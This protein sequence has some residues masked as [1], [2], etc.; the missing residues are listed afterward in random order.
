MDDTVASTFGL[1][2]PKCGSDSRLSIVIRAWANL[3]IDGTEPYGDHEWDQDSPC[4][5]SDC[6]HTANV[7]HFDIDRRINKALSDK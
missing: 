3:G 4:M 1:E 7:M 5:C 2:C 6:G